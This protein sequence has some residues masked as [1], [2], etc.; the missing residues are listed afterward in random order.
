[1]FIDKDPEDILK[2]F[3][4]LFILVF[5]HYEMRVVFKFSNFYN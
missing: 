4:L 5:I 1:M 2:L 3:I